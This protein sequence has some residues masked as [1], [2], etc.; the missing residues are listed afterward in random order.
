MGHNHHH[1]SGRNVDI[2]N[3]TLGAGLLVHNK[4]S[5][6]PIHGGAIAS[7]PQPLANGIV[8]IKQT[9]YQLTGGALLNRLK[10]S[11]KHKKDDDHS[12]NIQFII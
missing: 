6:A 2:R 3:R 12:G 11:H 9:G 5:L 10:Y 8:G 7:Q 1:V 4:A